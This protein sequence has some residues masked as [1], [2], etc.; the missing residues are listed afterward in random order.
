VFARVARFEGADGARLTRATEEI[1]KQAEEAGGPPP[2]IPSKRL[3]VLQD[4]DGGRALVITMFESEADYEEGDRTLNGMSPPDDG[5]GSRAGVDKYEV[6]IE[7][8]A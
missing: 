7:L 1:R 4:A 3:L 2:G 5:L 8:S 6:A